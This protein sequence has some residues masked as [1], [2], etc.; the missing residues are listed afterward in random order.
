MSDEVSGNIVSYLRK[1]GIFGGCSGERMQSLIYGMWNK[2]EYDLKDQQKLAGQLEECSD[3]KVMK[4]V[5]NRKTFNYHFWRGRFHILPQ[6]YKC[7]HDLCLNNSLQV[8]LIGN[9]RDQVNS[10]IYLI[11]LMSFLIWLH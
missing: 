6:S 4:S 11:M 3:S 9:Q 7:S 1:C 2:A 5:L 8:L 10:L